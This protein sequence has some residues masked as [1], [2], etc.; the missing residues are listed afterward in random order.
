MSRLAT[1]RRAD[2]RMIDRIYNLEEER[3]LVGQ[4]PARANALL[5]EQVR[6]IETAP[7]CAHLQG[8]DTHLAEIPATLVVVDGQCL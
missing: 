4:L 8:L 1:H 5:A 3:Y 7:S 6:P 2:A